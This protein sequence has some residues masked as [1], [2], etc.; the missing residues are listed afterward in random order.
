MI[1]QALHEIQ[2]R[3]GWLPEAELRALAAR[4]RQPL[5]RVHEVASFYPHYRLHPPPAADLKVCRDMPCHLRGAPQFRRELEELA[6]Q[7]P[8]GQVAVTGASC[9]GRCDSAPRVLALNGR[10]FCDLEPSAVRPL[11]EAALRGQPLPDP[12]PDR[13][14]RGWKIDPYDGKPGYGSVRRFVQSR[15]AEAVLA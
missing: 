8:P 4:L 11:V 15:D 6:A 13:S 1:L 14:P 5:H 2:D 7:F 3:C 10:V 9:V 12:P